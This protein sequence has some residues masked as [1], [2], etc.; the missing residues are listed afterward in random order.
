MN[1]F[2]RENEYNILEVILANSFEL[3]F[4]N[5]NLDG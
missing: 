4:E 5:L 2:F 1:V 3:E